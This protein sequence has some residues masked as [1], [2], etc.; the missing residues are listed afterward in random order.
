AQ[1]FREWAN[2]R[3]AAAHVKGVYILINRNPSY[4]L[5]KPADQVKQREFTETDS[6]GLRGEMMPLM[7]Q[8]QFD[9]ALSAAVDFVSARFRERVTPAA[10]GTSAQAPSPAPG[11]QYN[12]PSNQRVP[13]ARGTGM[14]GLICVGVALLIGFVLLRAL[15][16]RGGSSYGP[17]S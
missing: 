8:K 16:R 3:G 6:T 12:P 5:I 4:L 17:A 15:F 14:G 13:S 11:S 9:Q 7:K 1:F 10:A 2:Q